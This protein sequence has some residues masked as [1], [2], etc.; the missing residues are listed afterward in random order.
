MNFLQ[1]YANAFYI[2]EDPN[3]EEVYL[4]GCIKRTSDQSLINQCTPIADIG[5]YKNIIRCYCDTN[6]CNGAGDLKGISF[7]I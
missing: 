7:L 2:S 3:G 5:A 1:T 4:R 6:K